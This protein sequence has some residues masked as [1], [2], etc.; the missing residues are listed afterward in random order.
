MKNLFTLSLVKGWVCTLAFLICFM[1]T[2]S[3]VKLGYQT[4]P[5]SMV[6]LVNAP[7]TPSSYL[8]PDAQWFLMAKRQNLPTIEELV[9]TR[10]SH[11][12]P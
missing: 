3:Q 9:S 2:Y 1:E 4:P 11:C 10:A 7:T 8:S 12:W 5:Q 6:D